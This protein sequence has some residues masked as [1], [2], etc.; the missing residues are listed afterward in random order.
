VSEST[1]PRYLV[2]GAYGCIGA[3][4]VHQLVAAGRAVVT[5]DASADPYRLRLLMS[6]E[7]LAGVAQVRGDITDLATLETV[8]DEHAITNVIHLAALQVPFCRQDPPLGARV[9]VVGTVNVFEAARRR[10]GRIRNVVYASSIAAYDAIDGDLEA[11]PAMGGMPSTL[12]GVYKRANEGTAHVYW[13]DHQVAS[14]GLRPHTVFGVGRD[15]GLTSAPTFALLAAAT[16]EAYHIPYGGRYQLQYAQDVARDFIAA[17][18]ASFAGASVHN[19]GGDVTDIAELIA[20]I[21]RAV[22]ESIGT[23]TSDPHSVLPFPPGADASGLEAILGPRT[24][25]PLDVAVAETIERFRRLQ[26]RGLLA[27]RA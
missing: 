3:W 16:G 21:G 8:L 6:D 7:A 12:Y 4:T 22:P 10:A 17:S 1:D 27:P 2:T 24:D 19:L 9:N 26:E 20:T 11:P 15:Q 14:I 13:A 18:D 23:I 25:A 5:L